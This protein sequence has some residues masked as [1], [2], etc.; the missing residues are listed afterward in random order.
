MAIVGA[1]A[2]RRVKMHAARGSIQRVAVSAA[3]HV[4]IGI[5][6]IYCTRRLFAPREVAQFQFRVVQETRWRN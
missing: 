2:K 5:V 3:H 6:D 4:P 1:R